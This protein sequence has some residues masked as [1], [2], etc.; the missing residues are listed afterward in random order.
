MSYNPTHNDDSLSEL[1]SEM[2]DCK[3]ICDRMVKSSKD[4][5]SCINW[6]NKALQ[7]NKRQ[8]I[9]F[10]QQN[11]NKFT[12]KENSFFNQFYKDKKDKSEVKD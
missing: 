11:K 8:T 5:E 10:I 3:L 6:F 7:I 12:E 2:N 1:I 4:F 9:L